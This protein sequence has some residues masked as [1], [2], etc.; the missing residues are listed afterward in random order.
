M[1]NDSRNCRQNP[2]RLCRLARTWLLSGLCAAASLLTTHAQLEWELLH[3]EPTYE[4]LNDIAYDG[5]R[6]VAVGVHDTIVTSTDGTNWTWVK[7]DS[8]ASHNGVA[9]GDGHWMTEG[10]SNSEYSPDGTNWFATS[11]SGNAN[12][13][14]AVAHGNHRFVSV[15]DRIAYT[16]APGHWQLSDF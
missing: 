14:F 2:A 15:G 6:F 11:R 12:N 5:S 9:T 10:F 3:P 16:T 1:N 4:A 7:G 13:Q 8:R